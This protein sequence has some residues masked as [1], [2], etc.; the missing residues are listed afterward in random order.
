MV[1]AVQLVVDAVQLVVDA[2][3]LVVNVVQLV[4]DAVQLVVDAVQLLLALA[5]LFYIGTF[6]ACKLLYSNVVCQ[7]LC[8]EFCLLV[9]CFI[10]LKGGI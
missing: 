2:L 3:Q 4:V 7:Y 5:T 10:G 9:V 1:D 8:S 6:F